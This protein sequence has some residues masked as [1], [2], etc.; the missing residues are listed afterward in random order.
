[1]NSPDKTDSVV[2]WLRK[3]ET[4]DHDAASE[5][6]QRYFSKLVAAAAQ[7]IGH[8]PRRDYDEEDVALSVFCSLNK[9]AKAGRL[10]DIASRDALWRLLVSITAQKV[11]DRVRAGN[12]QKRGGGNVR[13]ESIFGGNASTDQVV[14]FD[15]FFGSDPTPE[16]LASMDERFQQLLNDLPD[17]VF[18]TIALMRMQAFSNQEIGEELAISTRS[19]ERKLRLIREE[20]ECYL[21][22]LAG[23]GDV[24]RS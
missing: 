8:S 5:L 13:G 2:A 21:N 4:G 19:V 6:W 10:S 16:T 15:N 23:D 12:A 3:L 17:D 11:I 9:C 7:R 24:S 14:G 22:Q 18:R 20:W 1:M